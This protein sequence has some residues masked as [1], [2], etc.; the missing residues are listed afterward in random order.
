MKNWRKGSALLLVGLMIMSGLVAFSAPVLA[1]ENLT[2]AAGIQA[3]FDDDWMID[4]PGINDPE[5]P[6]E[7]NYDF[8]G[9]SLYYL[10]DDEAGIDITFLNGGTDVDNDIDVTFT[11]SSGSGNTLIT[12]G[13]TSS[14]INTDPDGALLVFTAWD[15]GDTI[16]ASFTVDIGPIGNVETLYPMRV[17]VQYTMAGTT[18][19]NTLNFD[20]YLSSLWHGDVDPDGAGP[21]DADDAIDAE[22]M[23][24]DV[25]DVSTGG[26]APFE[27]GDT[28][29]E[30]R[31][32][33]T[34]HA[35]FGITELN[36]T[37]NSLDSQITL[38]NDVA[39]KPAATAAGTNAEFNYRLDVAANTLPGDEYEAEFVCDY[40]RN[41]NGVDVYCTENMRMSHFAVDFSFADDDPMEDGTLWSEYQ[42][43]ATNV[44]I[45]NNTRQVDYD[46]PYDIPTIDQSVYSDEPLKMEVTI[47]NNGNTPLY[48]V[49]FELDPT[50]T[51]W[52]YFRNPRFFWEDINAGTP[53]YDTITDT[54]TTFTVGASITFQIE[55]FVMNDIPIGEHRLP[56][57]YNGFYFNDG[58][59]GAAT[60]YANTFTDLEVI[61]SVFVVDETIACHIPAGGVVSLGTDIVGDKLDLTAETVE[62]TIV[63]DEQ[64]NFIDVIVSADFT[65]TP[66]YMPVIGMADPWVDANEANPAIPFE[67]WTPTTDLV[68]T[69]DVDTYPDMTPDRYPFVLNI[70]AVIEG[71][72][73]VVTVIVDYRQG[74]VIDYVGFGPDI[75]IAAFTGDDEIVPGEDFALTLTLTNQG[76][77]T[78][79]NVIIMIDADDTVEYDWDFEADFK[80]QFNWEGVFDEWGG[81]S[82]AGPI[83]EAGGVTW[84]NSEFPSEMFYTM[85]SLDVD[86]IREIVEIN[87]YADGVYSDPGARI[88]AIRILDLAPGA[89]T[90]VVFD[91]YADKDMVNGKPYAFNVTIQGVDSEGVNYFE[92]REISVMSSLPGSSY[93]PVELDWFDAGIKAL[94]LF[95]FFVIVLA[96]LLFVYNMFKGDSYDEDEDDF[97][98]EDDDEPDFEPAPE[99]P[100][101]VEDVPDP[102][103]AEEELVE[104]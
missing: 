17:A 25:V 14:Q 23:L 39:M 51:A 37:L 43:Y 95:L 102:P 86:N 8:I 84:E 45:L 62:V 38:Y 103:A 69:F 57:V 42:C 104:P 47:I 32:T 26:D 61:F 73:E 22:Y 20:V 28:F 81:T 63:N 16:T 72:L 96:I 21:L 99:E 75:Y 55:V 13:D 93:N 19:T 29:K 35:S 31:L 98:F 40:L 5:E 56:I 30:A 74:A 52:D 12:P 7:V 58:S 90:D 33:L 71:T 100:A 50:T 15:A 41:V 89:T 36:G 53:D 11:L 66:W 85:E 87:L 49:E 44:T 1:N 78:L 82:A 2:G 97:D 76:D 6:I 79:R 65:G 70:T 88:V 3:V 34:N 46:A 68:V 92:V 27:A 24:P 101:P 67:Q 94:G 64:Y 10:G 54:Y 77:D 59:L 83:G 18:E 91:M 4:H 9:T 48:N 80:D 60:S